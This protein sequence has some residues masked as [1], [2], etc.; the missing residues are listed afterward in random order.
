MLTQLLNHRWPARYPG[1]CLQGFLDFS[2]LGLDFPTNVG[3]PEFG[4]NG[5]ERLDNFMGQSAG[6]LAQDGYPADLVTSSDAAV[7]VSRFV[8]AR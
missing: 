1:V 5:H 8:S 7:P 2:Q 4:H 6:K 3:L